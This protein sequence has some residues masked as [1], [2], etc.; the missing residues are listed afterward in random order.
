MDIYYGVG[1][2]CMVK[3]NNSSVIEGPTS[4]KSP[5]S[6]VKIGTNTPRC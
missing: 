6:D 4:S 2:N 1:P 3:I 5:V